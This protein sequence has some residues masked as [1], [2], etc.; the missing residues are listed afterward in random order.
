MIIYFPKFFAK[1]NSRGVPIYGLISTSLLVS[2]LLFLTADE[3]LVKQFEMIILLAVLSSLVPYLYTA[4]SLLILRQRYHQ[5]NKGQVV[6]A[7]LAGIYVFSGQFQRRAGTIIY[8][9]L[10]F[11][12]SIPLYG[13]FLAKRA[14][15]L[16][17]SIKL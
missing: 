12:S 15:N 3:R 13:L 2:A 8:G 4:M 17:E 1:K 7:V 11:F 9:C 10:I 16:T 14:A 5:Q 6:V